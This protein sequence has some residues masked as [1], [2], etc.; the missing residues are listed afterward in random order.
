MIGCAKAT[1]IESLVTSFSL[2]PKKLYPYLR[3]L[4]KSSTPNVFVNCD[5]D[6]VE[7]PTC[8]ATCFNK[9][10]NSTF[11][12]SEYV[13]PSVSNLPSPS[14]HLSSVMIDT[15]DVFEVL[16]HLDGG[17]AMGCDQISPKVLRTCAT[18]LCEPIAALFNQWKKHQITPIPTKGDL[19]QICNY[20][21]ISLLCV[22]S[23]VLESIFFS[24][25]IDFIR[26]KLSS[27]QFGFLAKI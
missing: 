6:I 5:G 12:R 11:T 24:K 10:F 22:F 7:D 13:L 26:P 2:D 21:P 19:S 8:I 3:D 18:C 9:F 25:I 1:Y 16:L 27:H 15:S 4:N 23:K 17:K 14:T 20:K